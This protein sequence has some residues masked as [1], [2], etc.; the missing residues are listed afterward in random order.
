MPRID[1]KKIKQAKILIKKKKV[2]TVDYLGSVLNC[3]IPSVRLKLKTWRTYTSY[4]QNA[5]YYALP[6]VPQF[7]EHGLW[8]HKN[9]FFSKHGTL[10]QTVVHLIQNASSGLDGN[11]ISEIVGLPQQSFLH[12]FCDTQGIR[13]EKYDGIYVYFSDDHRYHQQVT[14]RLES[15]KQSTKVLTDADIVIILVAVIKHHN[16]TVDDLAR[17]PQIKEKN[18]SPIRLRE[19]FERHGLKKKLSI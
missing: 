3:S 11:Q 4:N 9:I 8:K 10:K 19:F 14:N 17:L 13:R 7:D 5:R 15:L 1:Q 2:F 6:D 12:H 18:I 16:I